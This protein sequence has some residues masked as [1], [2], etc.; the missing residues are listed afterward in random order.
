MSG[1]L[2]CHHCAE[3]FDN[4]SDLQ[5]H[6]TSVHVVKF[7]RKYNAI[8]ATVRSRGKIIWKHMS[9]ACTLRG[10]L[11]LAL[12]L[13]SSGNYAL[14]HGSARQLL[15]AINKESCAATPANCSV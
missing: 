3:F 5:K 7:R 11:S 4:G 15:G 2:F 8:N 13:S 14:V 9:K 10:L 6:L 12:L 1:K